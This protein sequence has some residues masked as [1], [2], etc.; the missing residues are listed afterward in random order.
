VTSPIG[1][2]MER[3]TSVRVVYVGGPW[4]DRE[5]VLEVPGGIPTVFAVDEPLGLYVRAASLPMAAGR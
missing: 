5:D 4:N 1:S 2:R 3:A